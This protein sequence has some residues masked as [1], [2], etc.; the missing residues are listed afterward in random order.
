MILTTILLT[1][2]ND[3]FGSGEN[4]YY[5]QNYVNE[6]YNYTE[7]NSVEFN[8]LILLMIIIIFLIIKVKEERYR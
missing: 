6:N 3:Y 2:F 1:L 4:P 5:E 7:Q 8:L